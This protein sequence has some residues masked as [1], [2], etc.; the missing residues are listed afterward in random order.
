MK[1]KL[2]PTVA[3]VTTTSFGWTALI[4]GYAALTIAAYLT[5]SAPPAQKLSSSSSFQ[6]SQASTPGSWRASPLI[7]AANVD[8]SVGGWMPPLPPDAHA[9]E[10]CTTIRTFR[11]LALAAFTLSLVVESRC[12]SH[13][14]GAGCSCSQLAHSRTQPA[15]RS[16]AVCAVGRVWAIVSLTPVSTAWAGGAAIASA[17]SRASVAPHLIG[18][19]PRLFKPL[20][21]RLDE[22]RSF[23]TVTVTDAALNAR[24]RTE[25]VSV[26][27]PGRQRSDSHHGAIEPPWPP[28]LR[29]WRPLWSSEM[30][31]SPAPPLLSNART[32]TAIL[33]AKRLPWTGLA[34]RIVGGVRST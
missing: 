19:A 6:S 25:N 8:G 29:T 9:G 11:P 14:P 34:T 2:L 10:R 12:W 18:G 17:A 27:V 32:R 16:A 1:S 23:S 7:A 31:P 3:P 4:A 22:R 24:S 20:G 26:C 13:A 5:G 28:Q 30:R 33:P 21:Q 15:P